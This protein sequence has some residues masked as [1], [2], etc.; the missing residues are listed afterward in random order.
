MASGKACRDLMGLL[1]GVN[2]V[3]YLVVLGLA[4]WSLDKYI[5]GEQN[6]PYLGGN[7]STSFMLLFALMA[8]VVGICSVFVGIMHL[9]A[10][11]SDSL[12][13]ASPLALISWAITALAFG[14]V[15]KKIILGGHRGK[16]LRILEAF[17]VIS[18]LSQLLYLGVSHAGMFDSGSGPGYRNSHNSGGIAMGHETHKSDDITETIS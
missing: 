18:L 9:R 17:I 1:L 15:C 10:W 2:F 11:R 7:P 8:G 14:F 13:G 3:V 16:P 6:H 4:S 12:A 5:D